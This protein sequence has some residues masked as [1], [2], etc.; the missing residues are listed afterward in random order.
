MNSGPARLSSDNSGFVLSDAL[1]AAA[2]ISVLVLLAHSV[3]RSA[4][5]ADRRITESYAMTEEQYETVITG[6]GECI[7]EEEPPAEEPAD[8]SSNSF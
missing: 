3:L 4:H 7:C 8:T 2:V 6:I 5:E 1:I